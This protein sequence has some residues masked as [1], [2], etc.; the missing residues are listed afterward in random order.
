MSDK[1]EFELL[2]ISELTKISLAVAKQAA[3]QAKLDKTV[4]LH[5]LKVEYE[6]DAIKVLDIEQNASLAAHIKGVR[7]NKERLE[8]QRA[9]TNARLEA[10]ETP[11][12][13]RLMLKR[14]VV[15]IGMIATAIYAIV[16]LVGL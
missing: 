15:G 6:L 16:K 12:K 11:A 9:E 3:C 5:I 13:V 8:L 2:V 14:W 7:I 10:L 1:N 4:E